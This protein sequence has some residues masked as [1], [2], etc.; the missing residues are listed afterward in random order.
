MA[1]DRTQ[2]AGYV[3][4]WAARLLTAA[5]D[6]QL[7]PMGLSSGQLP[8]FFALGNGEAQR[9][10]ELAAA[11]GLQQPTMAATL[12]RMERDG[13]IERRPDPA[14]GRSMLVSLTPLALEKCEPVRQA[15]HMMNALALEALSEPERRALLASLR[16]VVERLERHLAD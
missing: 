4:N 3:I 1:L 11:A 5:M 6:R 14:D 2:S 7:R 15:V 8:I 10:A 16:A 9:Q 13:L 12:N